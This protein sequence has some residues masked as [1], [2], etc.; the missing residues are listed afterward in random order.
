MSTVGN[1]TPNMSDTTAD[2]SKPESDVSALQL[3]GVWQAPAFYITALPTAQAVRP[4][5]LHALLGEMT[6]DGL[7]ASSAAEAEVSFDEE[8]APQPA[9]RFDAADAV[10]LLS[11]LH[12]AAQAPLDPSLRFWTMAARYLISLIERE[13]FAPD[14]SITD[15][16][17]FEGRWRLYVASDAESAWLERLADAMPQAAGRAADNQLLPGTE[18]LDTFLTICGEAIIRRS[19][20]AD[21]FFHD[22]R[23]RVSDEV[24]WDQRWLASL[25]GTR[26]PV[27]LDLDPGE[28]DAIVTEVRQ[29]LTALETQRAGH[30]PKL[31]IRLCEPPAKDDAREKQAS[32][33]W[34]LELAALEPV[35]GSKADWESLWNEEGGERSIMRRHLVDRRDHVRRQLRRAANAFAPLERVLDGKQPSDLVLSASDALRFI[36]EAAPLMAKQNIEVDLPAWALETGIAWDWHCR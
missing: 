22:F 9:L 6:P 25:L 4:D 5:M 32:G 3:R 28:L 17:T 8:R 27:K 23:E 36:R 11:E 34:R 7:L 24:H 21:E 2:I 33:G 20:D 15:E 31:S 26:L 13:Q 18:A 10:D 30:M 12:T 29:W 35:T 16:N 14:I 1:D 19:L